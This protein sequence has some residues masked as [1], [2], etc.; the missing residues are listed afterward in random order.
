[1]GVVTCSLHQRGHCQF[2]CT[3]DKQGKCTECYMAQS[4]LHQDPATWETCLL[5]SMLRTDGDLVAVQ[6]QDWAWWKELLVSGLRN[7][8][9]GHLFRFSLVS[10][11]HF[12]LLSTAQDLFWD[13]SFGTLCLSQGKLEQSLIMANSSTK[14]KMSRGLLESFFWVSWLVCGGDHSGF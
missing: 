12:S 2:L 11:W 3:R 7:F 6:T 5:F 14:R 9:R 8:S 1:M 4:L 13:K 10:L